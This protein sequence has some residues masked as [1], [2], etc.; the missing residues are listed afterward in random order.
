MEPT[1]P[2]RTVQFRTVYL[3]LLHGRLDP[4]PDMQ[5]WGFDGPV[6]GPFEAVHITYRDE[7][8][9]LGDSETHRMGT[10]KP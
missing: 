9:C 5:D 3:K 10:V 7:I 1:M 8:R 2:T 4:N 6:L